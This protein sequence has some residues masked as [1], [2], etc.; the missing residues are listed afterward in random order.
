M[1][2]TYVKGIPKGISE[3]ELEKAHKQVMLQ[4][5]DDFSWLNTGE[6]VLIKGAVNSKDKYPATTHPVSVRVL[7]RLIKERGG[8][9]IFGDQSGIEYVVHTPKGVLRGSSHECFKATGL[10]QC[11]VACVAFEDDSWSD[12]THFTHPKAANWPNGFY[13]TSWIEKADHIIS[14][15]RISTHAQ[16]GIT[17]GAKSWVGILRQDSRML[18]HAQGPFNIFIDY[19]ARGAHLHANKTPGL[20]F[21]EMIA[22]IQLAISNKLRGT[23]FTATE[24]Q[25]NMG[26]NK[27]LFNEYGIKLLKATLAKPDVS[28]IIGSQDPIAADAVALAFLIDCYRQT[29]WLQK[30]LQRLLITLN[31]SINELGSYNVWNNPFIA[32]SLNLGLGSRFDHPNS[33]LIDDA[34]GVGKRII[35]LT[36]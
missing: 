30:S 15:P 36:K 9:P 27:Y 8:I 6:T 23:I 4:T 11:D 20:D 26:P 3:S 25:I 21:F 5:L 34:P 2:T 14:L 7:G 12:F 28:L 19:Y 35:E 13:I 24:L 33:L 18:F 1:H 29:P 32:H 31:G 22:E 17:L 10:D 16:G